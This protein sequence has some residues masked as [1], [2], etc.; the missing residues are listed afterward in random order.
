MKLLFCH[1]LEGS[2]TGRKVQALRA[3]GHEVVAPELPR[4]FDEAVRTAT[5][6]AKGDRFQ[7]LVGSSRGGAV[8][9]TL[10]RSRLVPVVLLAPAW[11]SNQV[12]PVVEADTR[13][14]HGIKD[15]IVPLADSILLE[16]DNGLPAGNLIPVNDQHRLSSSLALSAL[17]RAVADFETQERS[18]PER[19][20]NQIFTIKPYRWE[21]I[22]VFDDPQRGL[23][24]EALVAGMPEMIE[25]ATQQAGI[26][27]PERGFVALFSKDPFPGEMIAL[28]W[29]REDMGGN[30]YRW[31]EVGLEG[32][33]CPALFRYFTTAPKR[34]HLA[35]QAAR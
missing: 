10:A 31:P 7:L 25:F 27:H 23:I 17:L 30:V 21:G 1:G 22:W 3:A 18:Q 15:T 13:I 29:V 8:A 24:K 33:L 19:G 5:D 2:P 32:W 20:T 12:E 14:I 9:M 16:E 26:P 11:R 35:V 6:A 28:E 34:L 4:D